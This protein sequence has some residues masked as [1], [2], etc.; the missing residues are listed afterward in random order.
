MSSL[1]I[2]II[3]A[4]ILYISLKN[5]EE[6]ENQGIKQKSKIRTKFVGEIKYYNYLESDNVKDSDKALVINVLAGKGPT[7]NVL[8]SEEAKIAG[9]KHDNVYLI[10]CNQ[11]DTAWYKQEFK[12]SMIKKLNK[13]NLNDEISNLGSPTYIEF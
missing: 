10:D 1:Q 3:I 2:A 7:S 9:F 4:I 13:E 12:Y 8:S 6:K 5:D 11:I